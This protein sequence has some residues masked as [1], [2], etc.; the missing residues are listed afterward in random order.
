MP[1]YL[2]LMTSDHIMTARNV[3]LTYGKSSQ[4]CLDIHQHLTTKCT[5]VLYL[6]AVFKLLGDKVEDYGID[7]GVDGC[8]VVAKVVE[9]QQE[10]VTTEKEKTTLRST[11]KRMSRG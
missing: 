6:E 4:I 3:T 1:L 5:V 7:A 8:H 11:G 9:H 10:T 2:C